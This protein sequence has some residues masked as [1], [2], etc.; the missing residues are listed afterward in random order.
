MMFAIVDCN[1]FYASCERVFNPSLI[2]KPVVVLSNNDGCI[3]ARS[4]EAKALGIGM[5]VPAFEVADIIQQH[6]VHV[7]SSNYTLY[8]DMSRRVMGVIAEFA[9]SVEIYSID[10][11]FISFEGYTHIDIEAFCRKLRQTILQWIGIPVSIG[12]GTTKTLSKAANYFAKKQKT[13]AGVCIITDENREELLGQLP[14]EEVWGIGSRYARFLQQYGICTAL[15][16]TRMPIS[17]V[18]KHMTVVGVRLHQELRGIMTYDIEEHVPP[19]KSICTSRS[20]GQMIECYTDLSQ[21]V[22]M[23]A[24]RCAADLRAQRSAAHLITVFVLSNRHRPDLPQYS[25]NIVLNL[26]VATSVTGE[27]VSFALLGLKKIYREGIK[28][29]KAGVILSGIVPDAHVQQS[30]FE[31]DHTRER[32][33]KVMQVVDR[34]HRQHGRELVFPAAVLGQQRWTLKREKLSPCYTTRWD[35]ILTVRV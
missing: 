20:F 28:Y 4:E 17:W 13:Y 29:K 1:N 2:G 31:N 19:R 5:G 14:A 7:F 18:Q 8:G 6:N 25:S 10:E 11:A 33:K 32:M 30:L 9:P 27:I 16:F 35:D 26:P 23:F 24:T 34:L 12:V 3:I 22:A 21:A 15:D